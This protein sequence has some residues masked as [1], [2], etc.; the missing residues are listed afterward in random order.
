MQVFVVGF[1][2]EAQIWGILTDFGVRKFRIG[3]FFIDLGS[4]EPKLGH[5]VMDLG[6]ESLNLDLC[7]GIWVRKV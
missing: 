3:A 4:E 1:G 5:F 7:G 6:Q 2:S